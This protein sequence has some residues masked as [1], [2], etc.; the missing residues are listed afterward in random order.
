[1]IFKDGEFLTLYDSGWVIV[2]IKNFDLLTFEGM[3]RIED[4]ENTKNVFKGAEE[5]ADRS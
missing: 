5:Q 4:V 3:N 1:M 2:V